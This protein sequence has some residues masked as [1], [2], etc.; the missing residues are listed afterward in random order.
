MGLSFLATP[1]ATVRTESIEKMSLD[2]A[3]LRHEG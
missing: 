2:L 1:A 3:G